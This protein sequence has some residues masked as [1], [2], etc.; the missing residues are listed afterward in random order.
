MQAGLG[1]LEVKCPDRR[2]G[3]GEGVVVLHYFDLQDG[4]IT[5]NKVYKNP[6]VKGVNRR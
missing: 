5:E 3:A 2:C 6:N 1:L 4:S